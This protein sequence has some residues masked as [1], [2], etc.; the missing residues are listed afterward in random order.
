MDM[1]NLLIG[2]LL[3]VF[4]LIYLIYSKKNSMKELMLY[5]SQIKINLGLIGLIMV[6]VFMVIREI[7]KI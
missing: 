1:Y 5:S 3:I 7:N 4:G 2:I 6:G